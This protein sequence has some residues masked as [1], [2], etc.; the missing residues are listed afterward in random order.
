MKEG[1]KMSIARK[2]EF[3]N[4]GQEKEKYHRK[5]TQV[6]SCETFCSTAFGGLAPRAHRLRE[7]TWYVYQ[8]QTLEQL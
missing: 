6:G 3:G 1:V 4:A 8:G 5:H 7:H 2:G